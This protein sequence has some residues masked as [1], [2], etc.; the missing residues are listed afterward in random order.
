MVRQKRFFISLATISVA[1]VILSLFTVTVKSNHLD[2]T[3]DKIDDFL[4][5]DLKEGSDSDGGGDEL[6]LVH[7]HHKE[8]N[9]HLNHE[10]TIFEQNEDM[11]DNTNHTNE[12]NVYYDEDDEKNDGKNRRRRNLLQAPKTC[13]ANNYLDVATNKCE[14]CPTSS[15]SPSGSVG[16]ASCLCAFN[17]WMDFSISTCV[18]CPAS[19][20]SL[21][22]STS[23]AQCK[24]D[25]NHYAD[26]L[27]GLCPAC[28]A[29]SQTFAIGSVGQTSCKC[30]SGTY[31][32]LTAPTG[33][34]QC[35]SCPANSWSPVD[36]QNGVQ[37]SQSLFFYSSL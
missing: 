17:T 7:I 11:E 8:K 32:N 28:P 1:V 13:N 37:V 18:I 25:I 9:H 3:E 6:V 20:T 5:L 2:V 14:K 26:T 35:V 30:N 21:T 10:D 19:S 15:T 22:G 34:V 4:A 24:C 27:T 36:T 31:K 23:L 12:D 33:T 29:N 16:I